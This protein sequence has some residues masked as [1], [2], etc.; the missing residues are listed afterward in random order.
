MLG[1]AFMLLPVLGTIGIPGS[2]LFPP[3]P[4]PLN[5]FPYL[6]LLYLSAGSGWF[7]Y[8]RMRHPRMLKRME[9]SINEIHAS[10]D[11][12]EHL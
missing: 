5:S 3:P 11:N 12:I 8:Q 4:A 6:F 7:F 10:F 1:V 9:R 2:N